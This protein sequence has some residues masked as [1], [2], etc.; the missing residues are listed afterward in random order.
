[1]AQTKGTFETHDFDNFRLHVYHTNDALGDASYIVEGTQAVVTL[2][3]PL[4][5]E[6]VAEYDSTIFKYKPAA[7]ARAENNGIFIAQNLKPIAYRVYAVQD[8]NDNQIY[9][10]GSDQVGFLEGTYNPREQPDFA[11]WY[12]SIRRYVTAEP[13]LYFRMFTDKA[14]RR[15]V[16]EIEKKVLAQ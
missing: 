14:F 13:Q 10:P 6:N 7:I 16:E 11:M 4:F 2:E 5:R 3:Q 12:D 8:K 9:E 1:M 15:Q